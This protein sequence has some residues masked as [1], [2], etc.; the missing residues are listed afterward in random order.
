MERGIVPKR[1][2]ATTF[3]PARPVFQRFKRY[4][5]AKSKASSMTKTKVLISTPINTKLKN[6]Y[7]FMVYYAGWNSKLYST[8]WDCNKTSKYLLPKKR[9]ATQSLKSK[10]KCSWNLTG[11]KVKKL[12]HLY[13]ADQS[14]VGSNK[15]LPSAGLLV[16]KQTNVGL[17]S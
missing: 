10:V 11:N 6:D 17:W 12:L 8:K 16:W 4:F 13:W 15:E 14:E 9:R 2:D 3:Q 5:L 7:T 1:S